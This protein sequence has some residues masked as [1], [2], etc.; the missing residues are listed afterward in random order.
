MLF[1]STTNVE[2]G[3]T[4]NQ[5]MVPEELR[6]R[7]MT[8]AHAALLSAHQ[9]IKRTQEKVCDV[10]YWPSVLSGEKRFVMSCEVCQKFIN[11]RGI[12][13]AELGHLPLISVPFKMI[14][15]DIAGLIEP[16]S[17]SGNRYILYR[18]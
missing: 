18:L 16:M 4:K 6:N 1:R 11:K 14:C 13:R 2:T 17:S 12:S 10:C 5:L 9:S 7:V 8:V 3:D 15:V